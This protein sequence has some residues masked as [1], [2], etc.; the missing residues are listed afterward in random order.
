MTENN[1][2]L[3]KRLKSIEEMV[4]NFLHAQP[5]DDEECEKYLVKALKDVACGV[6]DFLD[7]GC[8]A[9]KL[10]DMTNVFGSVDDLNEVAHRMATMHK[11]LVQ[12][13]GSSFVIPF[14]REVAK[15]HRCGYTD[16]RNKAM[17]EACVAMCEALEK[18][19]RIGE[20]DMLTFAV[21]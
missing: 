6:K 11:A 15:M 21:I 19:Y 16:G 10:K 9:D 8:V 4:L 1:E 5:N 12:K 2:K 17:G 18:K 20:D 13:F 3:R 14:V 7:A